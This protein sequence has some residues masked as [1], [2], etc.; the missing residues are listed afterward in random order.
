M[1]NHKLYKEHFHT[2]TSLSKWSRCKY[3]WNALQNKQVNIYEEPINHIDSEAL[4]FGNTFHLC[5]EYLY[6]KKDPE[7]I[8]QLHMDQVPILE[9]NIFTLKIRAMLEG[10]AR[11]KKEIGL[12][13]NIKYIEK[14]IELEV[15]I[16]NDKYG[17]KLDGIVE[18]HQ[19]DGTMELWN[20]DHKT[21]TRN[22]FNRHKQFHNSQQQVMY[23]FLARNAGYDV[24]GYIIDHWRVPS[25]YKGVNET[26]EDY[27]NKCINDIVNTTYLSKPPNYF[28]GTTSLQDKKDT[29]SKQ[30]PYFFNYY[31][32]IDDI[33]IKKM[34][35]SVESK[36]IETQTEL[37]FKQDFGMCYDGW[38][39][40]ELWKLCHDPNIE[41]KHLKKDAILHPELT[42]AR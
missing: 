10:R 32:P 15:T 3:L 29:T 6:L 24:K 16:A 37:D 2:N 19:G 21:F 40:C 31:Y 39:E 20:I 1:D 12:Y 7:D 11:C 23:V 9:D 34:Y 22:R 17:G 30:I 41:L 42:I 38:G 26:N 36:I 27:L 33:V 28:G 8:I 14:E 4:V 5:L 25:L 35:E 13:P 18:V